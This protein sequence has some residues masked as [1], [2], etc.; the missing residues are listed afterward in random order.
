MSDASALPEVDPVTPE[1]VPP[2]TKRRVLG[3]VGALFAFVLV[4]NFGTL[5][6]LHARP[7][8]R[9]QWL[10]VEKWKLI[11][12]APDADTIIVGDS[13]CNQGVR[14]D[15]LG[16]ELGGTVINLCTTRGLMVLNDEW[17][18]EAWLRKHH[19]L[20][21]IVVV[22]TYDIWQHGLIN[23]FLLTLGTYPQ[24]WGFWEDFRQPL[25]LDTGEKAL[26]AAGRWFPMYS[27]QRSLEEYLAH[28]QRVFKKDFKLQPDGFMDWKQ[29]DPKGVHH[30]AKL[31]FQRL[32]EPWVGADINGD[33]LATLVKLAAENHLELTLAPAPMFEG[34]WNDPR[35]PARYK[36]IHDWIHAHFPA[37]PGAYDIQ[38]PPLT[39]PDTQME[40][41]DH[42]VGDAAITYTK[43]LAAQIKAHH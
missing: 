27:D 1:H 38:D 16:Q 30:D 12:T 29:A 9:S 24:P 26:V 11:D 35:M 4:V 10:T 20:K 39:F 21:R 19:G 40:N 15:L 28:P 25:H 32:G 3:L 22:H 7:A 34:V 33:S 14:P 17:M 8:N 41:V 18:V 2:T 13:T 31:H 5:A 37:A 6:L 43:W 23:N 36:Q 42:V